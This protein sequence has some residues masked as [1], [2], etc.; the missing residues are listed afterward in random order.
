MKENEKDVKE[1]E[2]EMKEIEKDMKEIE[3]E[4]KEIKLSPDPSTTNRYVPTLSP[5]P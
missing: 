2:K 3:K 4:M 1:I 5:I